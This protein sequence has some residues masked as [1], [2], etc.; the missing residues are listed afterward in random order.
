MVNKPRQPASRDGIYGRVS[1]FGSLDEWSF[2]DADAFLQQHPYFRK[3]TVTAGGYRH[4][5]FDDGSELVIR[6]NGEVIRLPKA[7]YDETGA[8]QKGYRL[9]PVNGD[10]LRSN[11]WHDLSRAEQEWIERDD[12]NTD[13]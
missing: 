13:T 12:S 5:V 1:E 8:R 2:S 3:L 4:Y 6:P 7:V 11:E 9:H 10:L